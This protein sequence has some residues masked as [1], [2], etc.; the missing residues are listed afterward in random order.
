[1]EIKVKN[2]PI[3]TL[4]LTEMEVAILIYALGQTKKLNFETL[5][6]DYDN[7]IKMAETFDDVAQ[8]MY[9]NMRS[10]LSNTLNVNNL[11]DEIY[12]KVIEHSKE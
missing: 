6:L 8:N 1:M 4:N 11:L 5:C 9:S 2:T 7:S 10:A 12:T 3:Y